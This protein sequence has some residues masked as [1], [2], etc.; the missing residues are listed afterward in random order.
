MSHA[1]RSRAA[2]TAICARPLLAVSVAVGSLLLLAPPAA[3]SAVSGTATIAAPGTTA[4]GVLTS[5]GSSTPF[6][7]ALPADASCPADTAHHGYHVYSYLVPEGTDLAAV[8]FVD[9]PSEGYGLD[10]SGRYYGAVNTALRTGQIIG[11]PNDFEWGTLIS[12]VGLSTLV[13]GSSHGVWEAGIACATTH[14]V[15]ARSWNTQVTFTANAG[16]P[17]GFT[18][19]AVPGAL[20]GSTSPSAAPTGHA[21]AA[22][23]GT[24]AASSARAVATGGAPAPGTATA[25]APAPA[26]A[27]GTAAGADH[28][29]SS[30][31]GGTAAPAG[32]GAAAGRT[33]D[34][35]ATGGSGTVGAGAGGSPAV[36]DVPVVAVCAGGLALAVGLY[37]LLRRNVRPGSASAARGSVR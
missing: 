30:A 25:G 13:G 27:P 36:S 6:T 2:S 9:F 33:P 20:A 24:V 35:G 34:D 17:H 22:G 32:G 31:A 16:D 11:I 1:F 8:R 3:A 15:L 14:G 5:G 23:A 28:G 19:K 37:L 4:T 21:V 29:A 18:W 7:V 26:S 10:A 12:S